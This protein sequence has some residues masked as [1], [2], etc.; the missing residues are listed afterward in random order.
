MKTKLIIGALVLILV[1][2]STQSVLEAIG[3]AI[4]FTFGW[5]IAEV[6]LHFIEN[7]KK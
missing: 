6:I 1:I 4:A 7:K 3:A 5:V 2:L